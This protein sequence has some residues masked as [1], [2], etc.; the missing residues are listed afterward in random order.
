M[1]DKDINKF[2][3]KG[4]ESALSEKTSEDFTAALMREVELTKLFRKEDKRTFGYLNIILFVIAGSVFT[5]GIALLAILGSSA[6]GSEGGGVLRALSGI[7][8]SIN[9]RLYSLF[10]IS[11]NEN[12][13][14]Y[15]AGIAAAILLFN[16]LE[17]AI[18]KKSY[19]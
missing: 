2:I 9:I 3:E 5:S 6:T 13:L 1:D 7:F 17:K 16:F 4:F 19:N 15:M 12:I 10:G 18:F 14:M 8:D 11:F